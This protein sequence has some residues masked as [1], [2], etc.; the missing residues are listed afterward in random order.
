MSA[1]DPQMLAELKRGTVDVLPEAQLLEKLATDKPL[2]VKLGI[3]PTASELH[4]GHTVLL[5]KLKTFQE[6]GHDILFLVGDFTGMIGD[7]TG[8][9][10]T[11]PMLTEADIKANAANYQAQVFK[12]LDA[13]KT[14]VLY[15]SSWMH[16]K[17]AADMIRLASHQTVARMLER[18]DFHQ[19]Y[20]NGQGIGIHEFLYPLLQGYDSVAMQADV[21]LG[22]TDQTFN[23]LMGRELQKVYQQSQQVIITMPLLVGLD[24]TQ[25][26]SKSLGNAI[27]INDAPNEMF[28][29]LMSV[30]DELMWSYLELLSYQPMS[31]IDGWRQDVAEGTNPRDIKIRMATEIVARFHNEAAAEQ[32]HQ[33]F[34][35][36]FQRHQL[37]DNIPER[38]LTASGDSLPLAN[39]L[40][41]AELVSS[42]SEALR[43]LKQGAVRIDQAGVSDNLPISADG[44]AHIYQVGKRRIARVVLMQGE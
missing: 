27:G 26:M 40:K 33:D 44:S 32:A 36:R 38:Q 43:M 17:S 28:G 13:N 39:L 5:N 2:R 12:I 15:N 3:D 20:T 42:T 8:K 30:N 21:E 29:Q 4:L 41:Q 23:L 35:N 10:V 25:K 34:V 37:P 6:F 7:P 9:N 19:R 14:E 1:I 11:R 31:V 16:D 22:G 24:G 18:E